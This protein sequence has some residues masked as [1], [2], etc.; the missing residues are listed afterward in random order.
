MNKYK[1]KTKKNIIKTNVAKTKRNNKQTKKKHNTKKYN[2]KKG[3]T[4]EQEH[5]ISLFDPMSWLGVKDPI[6]DVFFKGMIGYCRL[7]LVLIPV[8]DNTTN[9]ISKLLNFISNTPNNMIGKTLKFSMSTQF[10][11]KISLLFTH[12]IIDGTTLASNLLVPVGSGINVASA[13]VAT[14]GVGA[15]VGAV[16][17]VVGTAT[18]TIP[19]FTNMIKRGLGLAEYISSVY[20]MNTTLMKLQNMINSSGGKYNRNRKS[21]RN[22]LLKKNNTHKK[23]T[24]NIKFTGG[25]DN[26]IEKLLS[27]FFEIDMVSFPPFKIKEDFKSNLQSQ[28]IMFSYDT[29]QHYND[30]NSINIMTPLDNMMQ[31]IEYV[32]SN[33]ISEPNNKDSVDKLCNISNEMIEKIAGIISSL[34]TNTLQY[35]GSIVGTMFEMI[36]TNCRGDKVYEI[37]KQMLRIVPINVTSLLVDPTKAKTIINDIIDDMYVFIA[38]QPDV[39]IKSIKST[40]DELELSFLDSISDIFETFGINAIKTQ[41]NELL[42]TKIKDTILST[43]D[44][45]YLMIPMLVIFTKINAECSVL[46]KNTGTNTLEQENEEDTNKEKEEKGEGTNKNGK[47]DNQPDRKEREKKHLQLQLQQI[48]MSSTTAPLLMMLLKEK[49]KNTK[50]ETKT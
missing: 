32:V 12:I 21:R 7:L 46:N 6:Y 5:E 30:I 37:I 33:F 15:P 16:G 14:T 41:F 39:F 36:L 19:V 10:I 17:A 45:L 1:F 44:I 28:D 48:K 43:I 38:T 35:D 24:S 47:V 29:P 4:N 9:P 8:D 25:G 22:K 20:S 23:N 40:F 42:K 2:N 3:G 31:K 49:A 27:E 11:K 34:I 26:P 13:S 18:S 50:I